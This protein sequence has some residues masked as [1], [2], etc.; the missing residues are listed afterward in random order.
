MAPLTCEISYGRDVQVEIRGFGRTIE[1]ARIWRS[2]QLPCRDAVSVWAAATS[3]Y[4]ATFP[5]KF[6][7]LVAWHYPDTDSVA[8]DEFLALVEQVEGG[9]P[10]ARY[11]R[12][13]SRRTSLGQL[14]S[15]GDPRARYARGRGGGLL[16]D[17]PLVLLC[18]PWDPP[19]GGR[20][21]VE[22]FCVE[23]DRQD[24]L[25]AYEAAERRLH[26]VQLD[27]APGPTG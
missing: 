22:I 3:V 14:W 12:G 13:P 21:H 9:W 8:E 18:P 6:S 1:A 25:L 15:L 5:S 11:R 7:A 2:P 17:A 26:G 23:A 16:W 10:R 24:A 19:D 20:W 27:L 4:S